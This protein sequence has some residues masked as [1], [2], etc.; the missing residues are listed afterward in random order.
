MNTLLVTLISDQ[1][2]PNVQ[3]IKDKQDENTCFLFVSTQKMEEKGVKSW[4]TKVCNIGEDKTI[5][6]V[7]DQFSLNDIENKLNGLNYDDYNKL[8]VNV[9]G[10]TKIMSISV[11]DFFK[12]KN[13]DI[14]YVHNGKKYSQIFPKQNDIEFKVKLSIAEY[15]SSY[16]IEYRESKIEINQEYTVSFLD[17]YLNLTEVEKKTIIE[18]NNVRNERGEYKKWKKCVDNIGDIQGLAD[19]L[20][21]IDFPSKNSLSKAEVK[22]LTGDWY[23]QWCYFKIKEKFQIADDYIKTGINIK[24]AN[25][26]DNE[27]DIVYMFDG[28]FCVIECKTDII[29]LTGDN[30]LTEAIYK[31]GALKSNFGLTVQPRIYTLS[32]KESKAVKDS[33]INRAE[34]FKIIIKCKED[35]DEFLKPSTSC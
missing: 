14:H 16:G 2:I 11:T 4:I 26:I 33:H 1:T 30:I 35:L 19:F 29:S 15:L 21:I 10:G 27:L 9:T 31:Q 22:Y 17:K 32:S 8:I 5:T 3:F 6:I 20:N 23:E 7:V 24:N 28:N 12:S 34:D 25:G 18:L 13:A